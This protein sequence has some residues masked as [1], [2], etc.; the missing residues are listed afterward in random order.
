M[1][2]WKSEGEF[3]DLRVRVLANR[4]Q[5]AAQVVTSYATCVASATF[6]PSLTPERDL[7]FDMVSANIGRLPLPIG[8][9]LKYLPQPVQFKSREAQLNLSSPTPYMVFNLPGQGDGK[10]KLQSLNLAEGQITLEFLPPERE[11]APQSGRQ[12]GV[13]SGVR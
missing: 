12:R 11:S 3:Q 6:E 13:L 5:L 2:E 10:P 9:L 1:A 8:T 7:R 4:V